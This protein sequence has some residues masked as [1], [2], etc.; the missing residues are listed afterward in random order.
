M[1]HPMAHMNMNELLD[2]YLAQYEDEI[3]LALQEIKTLLF[4][5]ML[6]GHD[7]ITYRPSYRTRRY[8]VAELNR[9]NFNVIDCGNGYI[10]IIA[11][12]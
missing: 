8:L 7:N 1:T 11:I 12:W 10:R 5:Q 4:A 2:S 3:N 9:N 6:E